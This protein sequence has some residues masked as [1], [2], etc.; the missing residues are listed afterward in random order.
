MRSRVLALCAFLI[1]ATSPVAVCAQSAAPAPDWTVSLAGKVWVSSGWSNWNLKSAG[2][3]PATDLRWRGVDAVVGE[4]SADIVWR[5]LVWTLS[6]GGTE[7]DQ[8]AL[9]AED[10]ARSN[11][12][13]RFSVTRSSVDEGNIF[14][15][16]NDIGA[17]VAEWR[18][19]L[20]GGGPAPA[21]AG[22]YLDV[23]VGYQFWREE[24]VAFGITGNLIFPSGFIVSQGEPSSVKVVT[25]EYTRHSMRLGARTQVPLVGGL[26]LKA[27]AALSPWTRTEYEDTHHLITGPRQP[28]ESVASGGFGVQ[29]EAGLSYAILGGLSAEGG[30]RYWRFDSGEGDVITRAS[31]GAVTKSKL[32][33]AITERY[34]PY[35]GL[36]WR[37]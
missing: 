21:A 23:F 11:R 24:Y 37:F 22:G 32:N 14:Y 1:L 3:D 12:Q 30:F 13:G 15:I 35:V 9:I 29:V 20:F 31:N 34:G 7:V 6:V 2:V 25:N 17:R 19:P 8:G 4:V 5:R 36:S 28:T 26:S 33:E 18:Q 27:L 16:N 10:F